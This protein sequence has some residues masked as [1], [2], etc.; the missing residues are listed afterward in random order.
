MT[1]AWQRVSWSMKVGA[2]WDAAFAAAIF[3]FPERASSW[4]KIPL[5]ADRLH[6][7]LNGVLL[8]LLAGLY[9]LI[10]LDPERRAS[11]VAWTAVGR[12]LGFVYLARAWVLG[13][14][15]AVSGLAYAD[16]ALAAAHA[17]L[18]LEARGNA[19]ATQGKSRA[20]RRRA[21]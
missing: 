10:A 17:W 14:P 15:A 16:L 20:A 1:A 4:L 19:A 3:A 2:V 11:L 7:G 21:S 12:F 13:A 18:L 9:W 8:L 5:P 6:F